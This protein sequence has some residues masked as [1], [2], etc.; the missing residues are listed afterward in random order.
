MVV[1]GIAALLF[2]TEPLGALAV[3]IIFLVSSYYFQYFTKRHLTNWAPKR[4][5]Y[6]GEKIKNIKQGFD[7]IKDLKLLGREQNFAD[8]YLKYNRA[9]LF[10]NRNIKVLKSLPRIWLEM[11]VII[12]LSSLL[13]VMQIL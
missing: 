9:S 13:F 5:L 3:I 8:E 1:I 10:L 6:D 12:S 11:M 2:I 7:A 4:H